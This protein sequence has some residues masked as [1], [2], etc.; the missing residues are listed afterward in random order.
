MTDYDYQRPQDHS[1][2]FLAARK[3][4]PRLG[5]RHDNYTPAAWAIHLTDWDSSHSL[6]VMGTPAE[7]HSVAL[8]ILAAADQAAAAEAEALAK[9]ARARALALQVEDEDVEAF[10][11]ERA[12]DAAEA[13]DRWTTG[14]PNPIDL[15]R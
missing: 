6:H 11:E 2:T 15:L 8:A 9:K 12:I 14:D 10:L 5:L 4:A 7:L 3:L 1:T 13:E